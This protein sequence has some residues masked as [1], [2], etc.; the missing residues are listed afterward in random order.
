MAPEM[1]RARQT[2]RMSGGDRGRS[3]DSDASRWRFDCASDRPDA[4]RASAPLIRRFGAGGAQCPGVGR[5]CVGAGPPEAVNALGQGEI[6]IGIIDQSNRTFSVEEG[7]R[8][9]RRVPQVFVPL[10]CVIAGGARL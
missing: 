3:R 6:S 1:P 5:E 8:S 9:L 7:W 4:S 2:P 10:C